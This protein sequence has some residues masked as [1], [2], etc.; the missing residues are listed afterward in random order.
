MEHNHRN[1]IPQGVQRLIGKLLGVTA[2][3]AQRWFLLKLRQSLRAYHQSFLGVRSPGV[4]VHHIAV[5]GL[6]LACRA[7]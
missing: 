2:V 4:L 1:R 3:G 7:G 6:I 5:L